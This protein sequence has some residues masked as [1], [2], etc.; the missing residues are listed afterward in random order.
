MSMPRQILPAQFYMITRRCTQRQFLLRPDEETNNAFLYLLAEASE[1]FDID[2]I[3]PSVLTN[4]HHT[5]VFDRHGRIIEF[6]EHL[7]K[8]VAKCQNALRGRWE[9]LW[10]SEPPCIVRL[11]DVADVIDKLVYAATNPVKDLLVERVHQWPGVNGTAALLNQRT[12]TARRPGFFR[13]N[14]P[15]PATIAL[16]LVIPPELGDPDE[17]RRIL[18]ER[19]AAVEAQV[20]AD[21]ARSGARVPGRRAVLQPSV[22]G[23][24]SAP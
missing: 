17:I 5:I 23:P 24:P 4:H 20:A 8:F 11:V 14:G 18:R 22:R 15:M 16:K 12:L 3:L 9:N 10:S 6:V 13:A 19:V 1:R 21:R 2:V 7:H